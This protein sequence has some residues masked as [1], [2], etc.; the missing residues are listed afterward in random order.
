M[1]DPETTVSPLTAWFDAEA[2]AFDLRWEEGRP[3][4]VELLD[5]AGRVVWSGHSP[6][7]T[8]RIP[9]TGESS[10]AYVARVLGAQDQIGAM[11]LVLP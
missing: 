11:R 2:R 3:A 8:C 9:V 6:G 1:A 5:M 10:G 4:Y 7:P